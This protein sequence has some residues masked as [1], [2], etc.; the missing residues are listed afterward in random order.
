MNNDLVNLLSS[1]VGGLVGWVGAL[2]F[3]AP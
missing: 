3:L 1:L 2:I